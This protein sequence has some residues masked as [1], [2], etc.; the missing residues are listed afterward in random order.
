[1]NI[2]KA[3]HRKIPIKLVHGIL[4]N[5]LNKMIYN[6]LAVYTIDELWERLKIMTHRDSALVIIA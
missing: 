2:F 1:M 4:S 3:L 6:L 5:N